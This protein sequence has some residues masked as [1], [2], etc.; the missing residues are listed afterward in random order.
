MEWILVANAAEA[1]FYSSENLRVDGLKLI[2]ELSHPDSRKKMTELASDRPG[3]FQT[4]QGGHGSYD[5]GK[6]SLKITEADNFA[7]ELANK[8]IQG[9]DRN[10]Y[11]KL[12]LVTPSHF[13]GLIKKHLGNHIHDEVHIPKDYTKYPLAKL[14][15]SIKNQL[16]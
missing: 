2:E 5:K 3:R 8:L 6:H 11:S 16:F 9:Y 1:L 4:D 13:Y 15:T 12:I 14:T 7:H 10:L